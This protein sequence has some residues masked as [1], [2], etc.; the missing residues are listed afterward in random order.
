[1]SE[2]V[3]KPGWF[4]INVFNRAVAWLTRRG[5]SVWGS[6]VLAVR[7]RKSGEWRR[8]P[9]NLLVVNGERYLVAPRGHV[10]WTHNMRAAG[11]GRLL[12]GKRVEEFSAT[13]VA[14]DA[15]PEVLR[16]YLKRWK[17]EV[18][19]FFGGVGAGSTDE[20][21]RAIAHKHPVFRITELRPV[22]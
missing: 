8:T 20:E 14:D 7:G 15:K 18:G 5:L 9:V 19:V 4:T 22:S 6:R 12:L 16:A 2:H 1:M 13:E 11:G 21:L 17:A 10:Q 3:I